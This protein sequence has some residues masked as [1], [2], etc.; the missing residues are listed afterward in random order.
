MR[1]VVGP[2]ALNAMVGA[3]LVCTSASA[4]PGRYKKQDD[5]GVWGGKDS[6]PNQ[7]NPRQPR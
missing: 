5:S 7:C 2:L 1:R 6:G 3:S 4:A